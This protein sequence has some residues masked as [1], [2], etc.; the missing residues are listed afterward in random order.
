MAEMA[1]DVLERIVAGKSRRLRAAEEKCS[2]KSL[3]QC[4]EQEAPQPRTWA[5]APERFGVIAEIKRASPSL[6]K[7]AWACSLEQL[8]TAYTAGGA[9][10]ISVLTEE[11]FFQGS[12]A[13]LQYVRSLTGL[14]VLRKDFLWTEYQV[15]ES[16]VYGADAIL[17]IVALLEG[18]TLKRLLALAEELQLQ[19]L[20]E[21][22]DREE[23][24]LAL[25]AGAKVIGI[26]NRNLR[27]FEVHLATTLELSSSVPAHCVLVSESGIHQPEDAAVVARSGANA[28][29]VGESCVRNGEPGDHIASLLKHGRQDFRQRD[30][31]AR[32]KQG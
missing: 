17:L 19:V 28:V 15:V 27:T 13:D 21:C 31:R 1:D 4:L 3:W 29:L 10:A 14:P 24:E 8:V 26:N 6:G 32:K 18:Q 16:R 7:I 5:L 22:H 11:D 20:V 9:A 25:N 2:L 12:L 30:Q 23:V